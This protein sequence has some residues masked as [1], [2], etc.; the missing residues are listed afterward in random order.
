MQIKLLNVDKIKVN[1]MCLENI[2]RNT[3]L[4]FVTILNIL[5]IF[6]YLLLLVLY[7]HIFFYIF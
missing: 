2:D 3:F 1:L 7:S 5:I 4:H 6:D